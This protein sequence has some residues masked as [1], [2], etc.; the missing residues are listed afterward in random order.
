MKL[1]TLLPEAISER[2][3]PPRQIASLV[4]LVT[5]CFYVLTLAPTVIW[6]DSA[7]FALK[8]HDLFLDPAADGHPLYILIGR[9]FSYL[10]GEL[11]VN[12]NFMSAFFAALTVMLVFLCAWKLTERMTPAVFA[13]I[14]L[15]LSH[16]FWLHAVITEV[17]TMNAFFMSLLVFLM[18]CWRE[19]PE[20]PQYLYWAAFTFGLSLTHNPGIGLCGFGGLFFMIAY[21]RKGA[22]TPQ[23][24]ATILLL[25]ALG[26]ALWWGLFLKWLLSQPEKTSEIVN[27]VTGRQEHKTF[28]F[29]FVD[30]FSNIGLYIAY[31]IYQFPGPGFLLAILGAWRLL[32]DDPKAA[33]FLLLM[34]GTNVL[35]FLAGASLWWAPNY[36]FFIQDYT[37]IAIIIGYGGSYLVHWLYLKSRSGLKRT[38]LDRSSF[39]LFGLLILFPTVIYQV[40]P[41]ISNKLGIRLLSARKLPYRNAAQFFLSPPKTGYY[42][43]KIYAERALEA[44]APNALIIADYTPAEVLEY[45][46]RVMGLRPD[47]E[48]VQVHVAAPKSDDY[49]LKPYVDKHYG[50]RPIYLADLVKSKYYYN[51]EELEQDY[52]ILPVS[53]IYK[54]VRK[55]TALT[56]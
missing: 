6:G 47:I 20:D 37:L 8:V 35:F 46:Q 28:M 18:L 31:L 22:I 17:Y 11:A 34:I 29:R 7:G 15:T 16:A 19:N 48:L 3:I 32:K 33:L 49:N 43:P 24:I 23:K 4:F 10:P 54:V 40:T 1:V 41:P 5:L 2:K 51:V 55:T 36:V 26:S 56:Q 42:G 50:E 9:L 27:I 52:D 44:A 13:A 12:L 14:A 38:W 39:I 53:P 21:G 25:F 45:Y 30:F